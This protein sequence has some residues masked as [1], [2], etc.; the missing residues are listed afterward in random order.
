MKRKKPT[1]D[2]LDA[3]ESLLYCTPEDIYKVSPLS[4]KSTKELVK[5]I[6]E[7]MKSENMPP[8]S[9]RPMM[10]PTY[11]VMEKLG[12]NTWTRPMT[13]SSEKHTD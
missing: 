11:R 1:F 7:E 2:D 4:R 10:V 8:I 9:L 5:Q 13:N 3:F 6:V 12:L